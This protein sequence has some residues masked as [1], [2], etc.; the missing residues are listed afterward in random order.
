[1][2]RHLGFSAAPLLACVL[3]GCSASP[4][5]GAVGSPARP[6]AAGS[7]VSYAWGTTDGGVVT[8]DGLQGRAT[9]LLFVTTFDLASQ[10]QAK[11]LEDLYRSH[12]PRINAVAVVME[13]PKYATLAS[14]F[15]EVLGLS[16]P[17]AIAD[18]ATRDGHGP[19]GAITS[20]PS[21]VVLDREA[22]PVFA[23]AGAVSTAQIERQLRSAQ[24]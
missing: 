13:P 21:W 15:A 14:S 12:Q 11:H 6:G 5:E 2:S 1:M 3:V 19:F 24:R 8:S 16:Y 7:S 10:A 23:H 22:R 9:V 18:D 20:V 17:V 4:L